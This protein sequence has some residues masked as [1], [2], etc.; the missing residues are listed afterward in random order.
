MDNLEI[1]NIL[2]DIKT[3]KNKN[4]FPYDD[5][6]QNK[7]EKIQES[8]V[9]LNSE[10]FHGNKKLNNSISNMIKKIQHIPDNNINRDKIGGRY[11]S[12]SNQKIGEDI[13]FFN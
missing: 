6:N 5:I 7:I 4:I 13:I 3:K 12:S 10:A 9:L 11:N 1:Y 2:L 8:I